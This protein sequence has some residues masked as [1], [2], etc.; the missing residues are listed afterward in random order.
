M[1]LAAETLPALRSGPKGRGPPSCHEIR[2][3]N[4]RLV[5]E[6]MKVLRRLGPSE[7]QERLKIN[8]K[9]REQH[10]RTSL[11]LMSTLSEHS[12][13]R[14]HWLRVLPRRIRDH[15]YEEAALHGIPCSVECFIRTPSVRN[16]LND[17]AK[18]V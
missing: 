16:V 3:A 6:D 18:T 15:L 10:N 8:T 1:W 13:Q 12:Q 11:L 4:G 17:V 5:S 2:Q 9:S 14:S 7:L